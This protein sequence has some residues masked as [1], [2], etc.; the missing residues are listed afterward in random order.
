MP[1]ATKKKIYEVIPLI[2]ARVGTVGK[3]HKNAAQGYQYRGVDD[4]VASLQPLMAELGIFVFPKVLTVSAEQVRVGQKGTPM[5]HVVSTIEYHFCADDGSEVV[6]ATI[7][8]ATDTGDK[9]ANKAMAAAHK[10]ALT[11][12]FSIPTSDPK[13]TE[14]D[15]PE[16]TDDQ[17][18]EVR[19]VASGDKG[20]DF[21]F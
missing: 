9:A 7:G 18:D 5:I 16:L 4:V 19:H 10:Y 21:N 15:H 2:M 6:T 11:Q 12:T 3:N 20:D 14:I 1:T 8:E 13:D 17:P